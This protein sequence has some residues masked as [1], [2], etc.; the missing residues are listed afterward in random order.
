MGLRKIFSC[1]SYSSFNFRTLNNTL[2]FGTLSTFYVGFSDCNDFEN[3]RNW[4]ISIDNKKSEKNADNNVNLAGIQFMSQKLLKQYFL[5][6]W[7]I[8]R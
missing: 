3:S 1:A 4:N 7:L 5:A 2:L 6:S 8:S